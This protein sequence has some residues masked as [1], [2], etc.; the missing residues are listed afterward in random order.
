MQYINISLHPSIL[1]LFPSNHPHLPRPTWHHSK[2]HGSS[3]P[4]P[5]HSAGHAPRGSPLPS[6]RRRWRRLDWSLEGLRTWQLVG[7]KTAAIGRVFPGSLNRWYRYQS[8]NWQYI[9]LI[10]IYI[11]L[12]YC[13]LGGYMLPTTFYGNQ[14]QPLLLCQ[15]KTLLGCPTGI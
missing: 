7:T 15:A 13:I 1:H 10:Y 9:A 3:P 4:P 12:I 11:S 14:K 6:A 2:V 5:P 8:P